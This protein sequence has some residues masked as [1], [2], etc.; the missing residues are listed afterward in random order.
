VAGVVSA[1]YYYH[2]TT[3][4]GPCLHTRKSVHQVHVSCP[5]PA[6]AMGA[7]FD[8][9]GP[10]GVLLLGHVLVV[11][12]VVVVVAVAVVV[13]NNSDSALNIYISPSLPPLLG[14]QRSS[15]RPGILPIS[16]IYWRPAP[17]HSRRIGIISASDG[18]SHPCV[19]RLKYTPH[20]RTF[21]PRTQAPICPTNNS[22][23]RHEGRLRRRHDAARRRRPGPP[24]VRKVHPH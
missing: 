7:W 16:D 6:L 15:L 11:I 1:V 10:R 3:N 9:K 17:E 18:P 14:R 12:I 23:T 19:H 5:V 20:T 21:S 22:L 13:V 2:D 8:I 24:R 4:G